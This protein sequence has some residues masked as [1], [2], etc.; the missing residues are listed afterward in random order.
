MRAWEGVGPLHIHRQRGASDLCKV[1]TLLVMLMAMAFALISTGTLAQVEGWPSLPEGGVVYHPGEEVHL[2]I[3]APPPEIPSVVNVTL[4][5]DG[6]SGQPL[7]VI[8]KVVGSGDP[9]MTF[10]FRLPSDSDL[11][12]YEVFICY[13][14]PEGEGE[15]AVSHFTVLR[16]QEAISELSPIIPIL[17]IGSGAVAIGAIAVIATGDASKYRFFA[18]LAPL[19]TRLRDDEVLSHKVRWQILGYIAD[20]PG[21]NY[22]QIKKELDLPNGSLS[23]HLQVLER[24]DQITTV[25]DRRYIR[26]YTPDAL[27][28]G[29]PSLVLSD[30]EGRIVETIRD[31]PR[32]SQKEIA[33]LLD[34][35]PENVG[36]HLRKMVRAGWID[37][38]TRGRE[39]HYQIVI[40]PNDDEAL[41]QGRA[42]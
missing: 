31:N 3:G 26:F 13:G 16:E 28:S 21:Q 17:V 11:G 14:N 10:T 33:L 18:F 39:T 23:Y 36:Y 24:A 25:R 34:E 5:V 29:A 42:K 6:P 22:S 7:L 32:I 30:I 20:N 35:R 9:N 1:A 15:L 27:R 38:Y 19:F 8:S 40:T 37:S 2:D 12:V 4:E 41:H